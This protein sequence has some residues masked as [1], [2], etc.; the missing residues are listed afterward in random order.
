MV[1]ALNYNKVTLTTVHLFAKVLESENRHGIK[2]LCWKAFERLSS[3]SLVL[4]QQNCLK[5]F[6][7]LKIHSIFEHIQI[8]RFLYLPW[9]PI[10]M[11]VTP[12]KVFLRYLLNLVVVF[13]L[14]SACFSLNK[15]GR[16]GAFI[17]SMITNLS[18]NNWQT[19]LFIICKT[20]L[21]KLSI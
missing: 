2:K 14:F 5:E 1:G 10:S 8:R 9:Y 12:R 4:F 15:D 6:H 16:W 17:L 11:T 13:K 21:H 3:P 19:I 7:M 20:L 18:Y